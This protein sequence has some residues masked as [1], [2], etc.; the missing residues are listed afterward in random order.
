MKKIALI[1]ILSAF[2]SAPALADGHYRHAPTKQHHH[3]HYHS[4]NEC[5]GLGCDIVDGTK[6]LIKL[7]FRLVTSTAA[8]VWGIAAHQDLYGFE[9]GWHLI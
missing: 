6:W 1:A 5:D 9:D 4:T 8:G 7:P 3:H 2:L